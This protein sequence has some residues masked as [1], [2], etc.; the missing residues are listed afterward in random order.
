M[1]IGAKLVT[2][3]T[4][5][6]MLFA[7]LCLFLA[8]MLSEPIKP[9]GQGVGHIL[10][11]VG[12]LLNDTRVFV[13]ETLNDGKSEIQNLY[14]SVA[15]QGLLVN[16]GSWC[17][18]GFVLEPEIAVA[19]FLDAYPNAP[20][21]A[22]RLLRASVKELVVGSD[23]VKHLVKDYNSNLYQQGHAAIL[24]GRRHGNKADICMAFQSIEMS[25]QW[26]N[27]FLRFFSQPNAMD[28]NIQPK[29]HAFVRHTL[30]Q[31]LQA[32]FPDSVKLQLPAPE[33]M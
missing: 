28:Q 7:V 31:T 23:N 11:G 21:Q 4:K 27:V 14:G 10:D 13:F 19:A 18:D 2:M 24:F 33:P 1:F 22:S 6:P 16:S 29:I 30:L 3:I 25:L 26:S 9:V 12:R 15:I 20:T 32:D 17:V 8:H 5:T